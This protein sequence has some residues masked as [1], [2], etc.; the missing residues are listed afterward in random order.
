M[1]PGERGRILKWAVAIL[2]MMAGVG[3]VWPARAAQA[4]RVYLF[5]DSS[6]GFRR[7]DDPL[8]V[9][10]WGLP[11]G[12]DVAASLGNV[13]ATELDQHYL[14]ATSSVI[15]S[16]TFSLSAYPGATMAIEHY[17]DIDPN[18]TCTLSD[19]TE[20]GGVCG[21]GGFL[22]LL[23]GDGALHPL[24]P[25]EGY[26]AQVMYDDK[27]TAA[28]SGKSDTWI[29]SYFDLQGLTGD[30]VALELVFVS[31]DARWANGWFVSSVTFFD[32]DVI[33]PEVSV[34]VR[35]VDTSNVIGPYSVVAVA[36]DNREVQK[37][38]LYYS[39][40]GGQTQATD[41]VANVGG[42]W[43][44][45]IPGQDT[46]TEVRYYVEATDINGNTMS[47]PVDAPG[48]T[49]LSFRVR[50]PPPR[51]LDF[52]PSPPPSLALN[53]TLQW[54]PPQELGDEGYAQEG[55]YLIDY[56]VIHTIFDEAGTVVGSSVV[57]D[58]DGDD[59]DLT[60]IVE[61][62]GKPYTDQYQVRARYQVEDEEGNTTMALGD[63]SD[64]V[65]HALYVPHI[66]EIIPSAEY[67]GESTT[68]HVISAYTTFV[69]GDVELDL[70]RGIQVSNLVVESV[71]RC[72]ATITLADDV[73]V[74]YRA[75]T[76][77]T[78]DYDL[79]YQPGLE[80]IDQALQPAITR[81]EPDYV[82]VREKK[83][84]KFTGANTDFI[85][86]SPSVDFWDDIQVLSLEVLSDTE[87]IV[88]IEATVG[89]A[90]G[91]RAVRV[92]SGS[93]TFEVAFWVEPEEPVTT[94]PCNT[95]G[96]DS[97][98]GDFSLV[99]AT[100]GGML[101]FRRHPCVAGRRQ[102]GEYVVQRYAPECPGSDVPG[103]PPSG[104]GGGGSTHSAH[105]GKP[106]RQ[107]GVR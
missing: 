40:G 7:V 25:D 57:E 1:T 58:Q 11:A 56:Q 107:H 20:L 49:W 64:P 59:T 99:V 74:G 29:T 55:Q 104:S 61:A 51:A 62:A 103:G 2:L 96:R 87:F 66:Q 30:N 50:L 89:A 100:L 39:A 72:T 54:L 4:V 17:Y 33:P 35:P 105:P 82:R 81:V 63:L 37:V 27:I 78:G 31:N 38:T 94:S 44:A 24:T 102:R 92:I 12:D 34:V 101:L 32:G 97:T 45:S 80:V 86:E 41:M 91:E 6:G 18:G 23:D 42:R 75:V 85:D 68:L 88:E 73:P 53:L 15:R 13:W 60:A 36:S 21:D 93:E 43:E 26:N 77:R 98:L 22:R 83:Q 28:F 10:Q 48:G 79:T 14:P 90:V 46:G 95:S 8:A 5:D 16:P 65:S 3:S 70:G 47:Y 9:W 106:A 52:V 76:I 84:I 69:D 67:R 19:G 71:T